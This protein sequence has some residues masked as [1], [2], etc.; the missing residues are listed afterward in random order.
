MNCFGKQQIKIE[1][2]EIVDFYCQ[3]RLN[4]SAR[5]PTPF[6]IIPFSPPS[7]LLSVPQWLIPVDCDV[8]VKKEKVDT[9]EVLKPVAFPFSAHPTK[10]S[11]RDPRLKKLLDNSSLPSTSATT[12]PRS[13]QST[14]VF[15]GAS[16]LQHPWQLLNPIKPISDSKKVTEDAQTQTTNNTGTLHLELSEAKLRNLSKSQK[17]ILIKFKKVGFNWNKFSDII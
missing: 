8:A 11:P 3:A 4:E 10:V 1:P 2:D 7:D 17:E 15:I 5:A 13:N 16:H 6:E 14:G 9:K 12:P